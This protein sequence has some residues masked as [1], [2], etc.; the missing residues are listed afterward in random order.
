MESSFKQSSQTIALTRHK[1]I[2]LVLKYPSRSKP[3]LLTINAGNRDST[4]IIRGFFIQLKNVD[5]PRFKL[6][7]ISVSIMTNLA[8]GR[9]VARAITM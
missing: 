6:L 8:T 5:V 2:K 7:L 3:I 4:R 9:I 1:I